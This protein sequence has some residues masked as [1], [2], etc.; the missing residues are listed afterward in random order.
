VR[1]SVWQFAVLTAAELTV[2]FLTLEA[3]RE[4]SVGARL[5]TLTVIAALAV[6]VGL[7][8]GVGV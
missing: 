2:M 7:V 5:L 8:L 4:S 1:L 3:L 6:T